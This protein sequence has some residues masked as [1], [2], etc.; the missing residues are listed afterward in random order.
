MANT[1]TKLSIFIASP[2]D[3]T[4]ERECLKRVVEELNQGVAKANNLIL[5]AVR[6]ETHAWPAIGDDVQDVINHQ[7]PI[8]DVFIGV[9][10]KRFGTPTL[11]ADSGT[12][13][14]FNR[15]FESWRRHQRPNILFYFSRRPYF[16]S[17]AQELSQI[18]RVLQF[19]L[20]LQEQGVLYWEYEDPG[21]FEGNLRAHLTN[22][23]LDRFDKAVGDQKGGDVAHLLSHIGD[24]ISL[25]ENL[26]TLKSTDEI[27]SLIYLDVDNFGKFNDKYGTEEGDKLL[28]SL[29]SILL[30][31]V[32]HKGTLYRISGDEFVAL[33]PNHEINEARATAERI[34]SSVLS[35]RSYRITASIGI[36]STEEHSPER[37]FWSA[38]S[39]MA[40]AK[41]NGKNRIVAEPFSGESQ[42]L[43]YVDERLF[44]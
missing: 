6:W 18:E 9:L 40:I 42:Q 14:E 17:S 22:V 16:P 12:E 2:G 35:I 27:T 34:Q 44:S 43:R 7:I 26:E 33:L 38:R 25:L 37:L 4:E 36:A 32:K 5:E 28:S 19:R 10:W 41:A 23:I 39:A 30:G 24:F 31:V 8:P 3:V 15:V 11:R 21:E 13:E 20:R 1:F 29:T